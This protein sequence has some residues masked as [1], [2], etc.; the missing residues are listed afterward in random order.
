[1]QSQT[2]TAI[3]KKASTTYYY[4]SLFFPPKI[5]DD[6]T[7]FY[8]FVRTADDFVDAIPQ[9]KKGF[10]SFVKRYEQLRTSHEKKQNSA[11]RKTH[12]NDDVIEA[13]ISLQ[14]KYDISDEIIDAFIAAMR[15]DLHKSTYETLDETLAYIYGSAEVIGLV[16]AHILGL[17]KKAYPAAQLQG[18]A[19]QYI[20][21]IRDVAEDNTLKRQYLPVH[22]MKSFGLQSLH[23]AEAMQNQEAFSSFMRKQIAVYRKWQAQAEQGY[24]YLP[25]RYRIPVMVAS[26]MYG[27]TADQIERDPHIVFV[28]KVKPTK[29]SVILTALK[30]AVQELVAV[31]RERNTNIN[32][33]E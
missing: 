23:K 26:A 9:Q 14:K 17:P 5:L 27:W 18:R 21:F 33:N 30:I 19:M 2:F 28:R 24:K 32:E 8:A 12:A 25:F 11:D 6:V 1:M 3:F 29:L 4:S 22:E 16:M 7:A 15:A 20:N 10:A 31:R 13:M